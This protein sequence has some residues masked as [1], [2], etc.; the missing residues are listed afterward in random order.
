MCCHDDCDPLHS[1]TEGEELEARYA[2]LL[3]ER[4]RDRKLR[5][6]VAEW[7]VANGCINGLCF[8]RDVN[9]AIEGGQ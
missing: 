1:F 9:A 2:A 5:E 7:Q 8:R 4:E 3:G 6:G